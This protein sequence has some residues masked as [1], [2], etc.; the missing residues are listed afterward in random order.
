MSCYVFLLLSN[1]T[2]YKQIKVQ[3]ATKDILMMIIA[4]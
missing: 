1:K 2:K 4:T 3:F